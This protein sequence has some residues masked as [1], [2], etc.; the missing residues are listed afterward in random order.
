MSEN[1]PLKDFIAFI[2]FSIVFLEIFM[3]FVVSNEKHHECMKKSSVIAE[4]KEEYCTC[5]KGLVIKNRYKIIYVL[6]QNK[7]FDKELPDNEELDGYSQ[8][9]AIKD[10]AIK[11]KIENNLASDV[12]REVREW[13]PSE[14]K[15][16]LQGIALDNYRIKLNDNSPWGKHVVE[17]EFTVSSGM[18]G[19]IQKQRYEGKFY[20]N[21]QGELVNK[22]WKGAGNSIDARGAIEGAKEIY[23]FF[24]NN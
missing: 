18:F 19:V 20:Y 22:E 10:N 17:T 1:S 6:I 21:S 13:L 5:E 12:R 24:N 4:V 8:C 15:D 11:K 23:D 7:L 2:I 3:R 16:I 9:I 14:K